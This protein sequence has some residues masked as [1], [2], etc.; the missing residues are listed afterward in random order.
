MVSDRM[1]RATP[2]ALDS[3]QERGALFINPGVEVYEGMIIGD[4]TKGID[5]AVNCC[6]EKK[7]TN[8]RASGSEEK[9]QLPPVKPMILERAMEWIND[10]ELIEITPKNIR[11]RV[12]EKLKN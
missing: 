5:L 11:M 8:H 12:T 1:G 4:A 7:L 10:R 6:R 9:V 3:L 2:Y